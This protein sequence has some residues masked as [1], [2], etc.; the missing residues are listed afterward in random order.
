MSRAWYED[1]AEP[2][3]ACLRGGEWSRI[4]R[5]RDGGWLLLAARPGTDGERSAT[6]WFAL[7]AAIDANAA[8]EPLAVAADDGLPQVPE[9]LAEWRGAGLSPELLSYRPRSRAVFR[10]RGGSTEEIAKVYRRSG[11]IFA[12]WS[13]F[14][15][16]PRG[17][18][19]QPSGRAG[20]APRRVVRLGR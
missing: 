8:P 5:A 20:G 19:C 13:H 11:N 16:R 14:A 9:L 15:A 4:E 6:E 2:L 12:R 1:L 7:G 3:A 17:R 18:G 10:L